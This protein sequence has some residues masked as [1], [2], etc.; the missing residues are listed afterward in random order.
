MDTG[1]FYRPITIIHPILY[2]CFFHRSEI[3]WQED[4]NH[5]HQ[6]KYA[7]LEAR[8]KKVQSVDTEG[9]ENEYKITG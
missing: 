6:D 9:N 7:S 1:L 5:V 3:F 8:E 2:P 4:I